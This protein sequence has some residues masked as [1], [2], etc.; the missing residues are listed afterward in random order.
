M[1][2]V[3]NDSNQTQCTLAKEPAL[4]FPWTG[5]CNSGD[6]GCRVSSLLPNK[7]ETNTIGFAGLIYFYLVNLLFV[8]I[9]VFCYSS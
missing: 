5:R 2:T 9:F 7:D 3:N 4:Q 8:F 6:F 1:K